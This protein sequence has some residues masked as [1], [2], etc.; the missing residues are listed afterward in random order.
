MVT[1]CFGWGL[2]K[3]SMIPFADC[4]N[5]HNVDS[6]Y[7]LI[8]REYHRVADDKDHPSRGPPN[9]YTESKLEEDYSDFYSVIFADDTHSGDEQFHSL[10]SSTEEADTPTHDIQKETFSKVKPVE[11]HKRALTSR[12]LDQVKKTVKRRRV[13]G[14][15]ISEIKE[16]QTREIWDVDYMSTSD[17]E[18]N[19]S[20]PDENDVEK[21]GDTLKPSEVK[22]KQLKPDVVRTLM[23]RD[24]D[25]VLRD[26]QARILKIALWKKQRKRFGFYSDELDANEDFSWI[27]YEADGDVFYAM[28]TKHKTSYRKGDQL[29]NCYG[30]RTNRF[31]LLNYGFCLRN[32]KYNSLGFKVFVNLKPQHTA[33]EEGKTPAEEG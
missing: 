2:P 7:E 15:K 8:H 5:H 10:P 32:N 21:F 29:F 30:L 27:N 33:S 17:E 13:H 26:Q 6:T 31:L 9:Y 3:T 20:E 22:K 18:D 4:I 19:D 28:G 24:P 12:T 23:D 1:R 25:L 11:E 16:H 14:M